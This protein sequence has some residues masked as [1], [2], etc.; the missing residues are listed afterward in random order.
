MDY[1]QEARRIAQQYGI[2]PDL[3]VRM[4]DRESAFD[5]TAVSPK[6][7][8]GLGQLMPGTAGDL[9]VDPNDPL[10]NL[11]GAAR[12]FKQQLDAFGNPMLA[13]AAYNAGPSNVRKYGGIPPFKETQNYIQDIMKGYAGGNQ[14]MVN[15][16]PNQ[17]QQG[18]TVGMPL[19]ASMNGN[20]PQQQGGI[21]GLLDFASERNPQTGLSRFEQ[22]A[23]ALDPL[24]MPSM[25]AGEGIRQ[26]GAM[27]VQNERT[28]K[29]IE[30][31][32]N[33]G[34]PEIAAAV[35]ANPQSA[36]N[37]MSAVLSQRM[38][39][40][41][42]GKVVTAEQ[43]RTMFPG[44]QIADG[45]YNLS[46]G[47]DGLKISKVGGAGS[48]TTIQM[49]GERPAEDKLR[50]ELMKRQGKDFGA[51]LDAGSSASQAITDLR[52]LQELAPLA[53]SG[54]LAGRL[55]ETFP[56][57]NDVATLRQSIVNRVGPSL[58]VE[59][60]GS[61]SDIEFNAMIN[62]LGSLRN[63]PEA[64]QAIIGVMME[65]QQFNLDRAN[66]VRQYQTGRIDLN[67]ANDQIA[68]LESQS[69]IP[70]AVEQILSQYRGDNAGPT[71]SAPKI[72]TYNPETGEFE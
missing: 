39:P 14:N 66:I 19:Q 57:F 62:S 61:T 42:S 11:D 60:S 26:R 12:Y 6:G 53:P 70:A 7:A 40:S 71:T 15:T 10:Q 24:I 37:V 45:L 50:E 56:E 48:Q 43:L 3:F 41:K 67:T 4:I 9:K 28:N 25:R 16:S 36:A 18:Q 5:P 38:T 46:E 65:K 32:K 23:A 64:N 34:Y 59:G 68:A 72:R 47:P 51:Y 44:E 52:I 2:D 55:A 31:L 20:K 8:I 1:R 21:R 49:P 35:E 58:R 30:W 22:F 63:T 33:N 29:T 27:R 17:N 69:R 54:P 13:L